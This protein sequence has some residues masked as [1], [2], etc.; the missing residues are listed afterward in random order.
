MKKTITLLLAVM[1]TM[2]AFA[3]SPKAQQQARKSL[4]ASTEL[5]AKSFVTRAAADRSQASATAMRKAPARAEGDVLVTL[6]DGVETTQ[7]T[8]KS[9]SCIAG[10]G[11]N[12]TSQITIN[13]AI[14][15][16]DVYIQGL[17][18]YFQ[19]AYIKGSLEGTTVTFPASSYVGTD[20]YG[21]EYLLG[22]KYDSSA[23]VDDVVPIV[24]AYDESAGTLTL[25]TDYILESS[26]PDGTDSFW[27]YWYGLVLLNEV[28][29]APEVVT[30]P[31]GL[32]AE[33]W[34]FDATE[35]YWDDDD[36]MQEDAV[37]RAVNVGF[38]GDDVY[39]QGLSTYLPNAWVKGTRNGNKVTFASG[40]YQGAYWG[41]Y[42]MYIVG[43]DASGNVIDIEMTLNEDETVL[44]SDIAYVVVNGQANTLYYYNLYADVEITKL[45]DV[46]AV[47][48]MPD[49]DEFGSD[50]YGYYFSYE[51]PTESVDG[52]T[53]DTNKLYYKLY[54]DINGDIQEFPIVADQYEAID[55]DMDE[56]PY[57]FEDENYDICN[58]YTYI[59]D[60]SVTEW[61]RVGIQSVYYG[62]GERNVSEIAW[63]EIKPYEEEP[64]KGDVNGDGVVNGSDVTALYNYILD[65]EE[66]KGDPNV[67][68][69][70]DGA[71]NGADVT[72]L[73]NILLANETE[74]TEE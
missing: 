21:D 18:Y 41:M 61:N 62:G 30:P 13:V 65:G 67:D 14:D 57:S 70:A 24:F 72:A 73:Y 52:T 59:Y 34:T 20:D 6:P 58:I 19:D 15:G 5:T 3:A 69:D 71:V 46:A 54:R 22:N 63:L 50:Q 49:P 74:E 42:D 43:A 36:V 66:V 55:E 27:A 4:K 47:P 7:W 16:S 40:Q 64:V 33:Q 53:L 11:S 8:I 44:S 51:I 39:V 17:A 45:P 10:Q 37:S 29:E 1:M 48:A 38:D 2:T 60:E 31:V 35:V 68:G 25:T 12:V 9:G 23:G 28:P 32:V 26:I 56:I